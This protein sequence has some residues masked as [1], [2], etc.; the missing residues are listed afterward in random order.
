[1]VFALIL[2]LVGSGLQTMIFAY[3]RGLQQMRW[4]NCVQLGGLVAIPLLALVVT[5]QAHSTSQLMSV[6]G[7]GTAL[8]SIVWA[9]P[10]LLKTREFRSHF[11][12]DA[13]RLL[14]YGIVRVP[15]DIAAGALLTAGPILVA[16]YT[17][18]GQLS[19]LLLGI[20]C[21]SMTGLAF[22]PV[23]MMLLARVSKM[24]GAGRIEDVKQYVQHL[25]SAVFQLSALAMTQALIFI[26]PLIKWWLG[27]SYAPGLP[28]ICILLM[29]I[30]GYMYYYAMRSVLDAASS[31]AYNTHNVLV[32]LGTFFAIAFSVIRFAPRE[33]VLLGVSAAMTFAL[34]VLAIATDR[35]LRSVKLVDRAPELSPLWTVATLDCVSL[36]AQMI[37][38]FEIS[39]AAFC[40]VL[41]INLGLAA[42]LTRKWQP[43]WI[44]FVRNVALSRG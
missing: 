41:V 20:T 8:I 10:I 28:V 40:A 34:Y 5:R 18:M 3:Y 23:V 21:L 33:Y 13:K 26:S 43:Q 36:A 42:M 1:L 39:K 31:K 9:F 14:S 6:T 44:V 37:F 19:Y 27:A 38:R 15:G 7:I 12:P 32:A 24:L 11:V 22:W 35:S 25:R 2:F 29:A 30:P 4:A 16:H 17:S